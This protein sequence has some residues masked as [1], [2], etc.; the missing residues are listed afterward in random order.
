MLSR[1]EAAH[2]AIGEHVKEVIFLRG[3]LGFTQPTTAVTSIPVYED[4]QR[5][6]MLAE[7]PLNS[8]SLRHID[9]HTIPLGSFV[10]TGLLS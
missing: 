3:V 7:D 6:I 5:E 10:Y 4:N 8:T 9:V 2:V 1:M